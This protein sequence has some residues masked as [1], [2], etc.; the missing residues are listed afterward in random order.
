MEIKGED[1][2]EGDVESVYYIVQ[3]LNALIEREAGE[4]QEDG[5]EAD[6]EG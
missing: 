3:L 1:I 6:Q 4:E 5:E 2:I